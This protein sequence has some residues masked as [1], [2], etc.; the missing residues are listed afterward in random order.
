LVEIDFGD[1][2]LGKWPVLRPILEA[3]KLINV[4]IVK[5]HGLS[6]MTGAMKNWFGAVSGPRN[7]LHQ[8]IDFSMAEFGRIFQPTL[9][10]EDASRVLQKNGPQGG[11]SA[12]LIVHDTIVASIDPVAAEAY[13]TR[14]LG[15]KPQDFPFI[16]MAQ[17][18]S[19]G[20]ISL[21]ENK[22]LS[23]EI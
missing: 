7:K 3:D 13:V 5:H 23:I 16:E 18:K 14:F 20:S 4:P 19:L 21:P 12:D 15:K 9:T 10:I 22:I 6:G 2:S 8:E 11:Q 1:E 17:I